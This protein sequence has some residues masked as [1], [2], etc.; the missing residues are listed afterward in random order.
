[1]IKGLLKT[2]LIDYPDKICTV[3]Y[4]SGC[5]LRC[6]YCY[7]FDFACNSDSLNK[8]YSEEEIFSFLKKRKNLLDGVTITGGEPTLFKNLDKIILKIKELSLAVKLDSN[9]LKPEV[10]ESL[11]KQK[12]LD[13]VAIDL[14]TSPAKYNELTNREVDFSKILETINLLKNSEVNYELRTTC[15]PG[16]VSLED[17]EK[18]K[19]EVKSVK[20]YCLQ[21]FINNTPLLDNSWEEVEPY[22]LEVLEE[23]KSF[24]QTFATE[25]ELRV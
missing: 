14:K 12:L 6:K 20:K 18:I 8:I 5:N 19:N 1:M 22:S 15:L 7:N 2:S 11:L 21:Q 25:V 24:V 4:T 17:L 13:Y 9:G 3:L 10:I 23:F 16:F